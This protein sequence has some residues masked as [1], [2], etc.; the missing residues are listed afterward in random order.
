MWDVPPGER[1]LVPDELLAF[2]LRRHLPVGTHVQGFAASLDGALTTP[3]CDLSDSTTATRS[4]P[5]PS[6]EPPPPHQ[7]Q[8]TLSG[9]PHVRPGWT[10]LTFSL[11]GTFDAVVPGR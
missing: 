8:C 5:F 9:T 11:D 4:A 10:G 3:S 6:R 7:A 1:H 2:A